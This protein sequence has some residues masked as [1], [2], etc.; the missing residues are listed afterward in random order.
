[1]SET[2]K[3]IIEDTLLTAARMR[4]GEI[5][6]DGAIDYEVVVNLAERLV[7][8][9]GIDPAGL[10]V[11]EALNDTVDAGWGEACGTRS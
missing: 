3:Q 2:L 7:E 1:M 9:T 10:W 5:S 11:P 4:T 6:E 8:T